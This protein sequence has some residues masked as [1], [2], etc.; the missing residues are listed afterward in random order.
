MTQVQNDKQF[1]EQLAQLNNP[2]LRVVAA[3]FAKNLLD[4]NDDQKVQSALSI[5]INANASDEELDAAYK[6]ARAASVESATRCG[7][8]CDWNDQAAHFAARATSTLLAPNTKGDIADMPWQVATT[9]RMARNCAVLAT[10]EDA[11]NPEAENQYKILD[12]FLQSKV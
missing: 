1:R 2:D 5:A 6:S 8:D 4:L 12:E 7:A 11:P 3:S 10:G 9:C